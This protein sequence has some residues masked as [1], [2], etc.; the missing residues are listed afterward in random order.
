MNLDSI[1]FSEELPQNGK[2][3]LN[4]ASVSLM[5]FSSIKAMSDFLVNYSS[6]GPDS[7][8]SEQFLKEKLIRIRKS[9]ADL[10]HCKSEEIIFTQSTTDGVNLVSTGLSLDSKSNVIIIGMYHEHH[11]NYYPCLLL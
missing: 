7:I 9:I 6:I 8:D 1:D 3:Y 11:E 10:I 4:N 2:I 5:P